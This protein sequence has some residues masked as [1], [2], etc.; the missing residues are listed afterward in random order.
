MAHKSG[1]SNSGGVV[2]RSSGQEGPKV[3]LTGL[4]KTAGAARSSVQR[5]PK[6]VLD[7]VRS[8]RAIPPNVIPT[9]DLSA[10]SGHDLAAFWIGH[11]TVLLRLGG[12]TILTDPVFSHRIGMKA[13]GVTIGVPRLAPPAVD[14]EHLPPIDVVLLSHAHFD[15]LDR[16]SLSRLA[17]GPGRGATVVTASRTRGL[18][19]EGFGEV[20]ELPWDRR[21]RVDGSGGG[22]RV[23]ALRPAH[24]GARTA[25]DHF[26][27]FNSYVLEAGAE[28]VLFAGDTASTD[29]FDQVGAT[30]LSMFGI[31]A[32]DPWEHAH[33]T[34]EQVWRMFRSQQSE[35]PD[36]RLL[37]MHHSTFQ[38]GREAPKEPIQRLLAAAGSDHERIVASE[39]GQLWVRP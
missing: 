14:V 15:H 29:A 17:K 12:K 20:V 24:W 8:A 27:G 38:L 39:V 7:S 16:P 28:R 3:P 35:S 23:R 30:A 21:A 32:Y 10:F 34:P 18:I 2:S 4:R 36:G 37:A 25:I 22:V 11:A 5:Y 6:H 1:R 31:G 33:A 9:A 26:R 19:P 13:M